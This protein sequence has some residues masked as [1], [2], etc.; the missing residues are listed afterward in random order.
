MRILISNDDGIYA[1]GINRL[2]EQVSPEYPDTWVVA[3]DRNQSAASHSLTLD[4]PL[5]TQEIL[6][7]H[8]TA[9]RGTPTDS[10]Y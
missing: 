9:V 10:V 1:E 6:K 2:Y 7:K 8:F 5:R 3:P 4:N